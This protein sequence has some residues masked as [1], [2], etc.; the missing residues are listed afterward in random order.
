MH[1]ADPTRKEAM[2]NIKGPPIY[3]I[4]IRESLSAECLDWFEGMQLVIQAD[5][6]TLLTGPVSDQSALLGLLNKVAALGLTLV[7]VQSG[8]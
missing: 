6:S 7:S 5:G 2:D 1:F 3:E 8:R 4:C